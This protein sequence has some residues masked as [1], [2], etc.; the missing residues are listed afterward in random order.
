MGSNN[1]LIGAIW[2]AKADTYSWKLNGV[3]NE[4]SNKL[5]AS[6]DV[7]SY[8]VDR[9][10]NNSGSLSLGNKITLTKSCILSAS[11][12]TISFWMMAS[13]SATSVYKSI[14]LWEG[15]GG[16]GTIYFE[17]GALSYKWGGDG[18][19]YRSTK[20]GNFDTWFFVTIVADS[21]SN[22][23]IYINGSLV[24]SDARCTVVSSDVT[25]ILGPAPDIYLSDL[26][27]YPSCLNADSINQQYYFIPSPPTPYSNNNTT[28]GVIKISLFDTTHTFVS[29][30]FNQIFFI[31]DKNNFLDPTVCIWSSLHATLKNVKHY[32]QTRYSQYSNVTNYDYIFA[33]TATDPNPSIMFYYNDLSKVKKV[34]I[35]NRTSCCWNNLTFY[36]LECIYDNNI[37][38]TSSFRLTSE[39]IQTVFEAKA[40]GLQN[41]VD[42][43]PSSSS[44][45]YQ[46][47]E[48]NVIATASLLPGG[49]MSVIVLTLLS[50]FLVSL[51]IINWSKIFDIGFSE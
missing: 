24:I 4:E 25:I 46:S 50:L 20:F 7:A 14:L 43:P 35:Y 5:N 44:S 10:C 23:K 42:P 9:F 40:V 19:G 31:G 17:M 1:S 2:G 33:T 22:L 13:S 30:N 6:T 45:S 38:K 36:K 39:L 21:N 26:K 48:T 47:Q 28:S 16:N 18:G 51:I 29:L 15:R 37:T 41:A 27:M 32:N 34:I 3:L 49:T 8:A 12:Y 11:G